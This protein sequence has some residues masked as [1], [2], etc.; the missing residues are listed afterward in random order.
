MSDK[1]Y[2][3]V[4]FIDN[5][6]ELDV[7]VNPNE[8]TIWLTQN[9]IAELFDKDRKT[10][11]R[12]IQNIIKEFE[13]NEK[14]VCSKKEHTIIAI[15]YRVK[16][17]RAIIFRRW[18]S[19]VLKEYLLT[20]YVINEE[21]SLVTNENYVRLINKVESLDERVSNIEN[22]YKPQ[23]FK[24]SQL[25]FDGQLYDAYTLI[26]SIFESA[27]NEIII[28]DNYVDRSILD[29]LVVKKQTT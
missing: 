20:G 7:Y 8:E 2:E 18:A 13:L 10:I 23:E 14:Q 1:K 9:E 26:Q 3:I 27:N 28:I 4:K 17:K 21:R 19:E 29:R 22:N 16:S 24:S 12:H 6:F 5:Q 25:F 15:G 11:T